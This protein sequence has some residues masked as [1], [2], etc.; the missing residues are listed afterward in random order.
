MISFK[1]FVCNREVLLLCSNEDFFEQ[2]N[3]SY[4]GGKT[5]N[6]SAKCKIRR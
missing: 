1:L 6:K 3:H 5:Q 2:Y 4:D